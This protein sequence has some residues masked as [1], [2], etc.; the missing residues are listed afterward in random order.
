YPWKN[1]DARLD[2][3][4]EKVQAIAAASDA[5]KWSRSKTFEAIWRA[6]HL[7]A[8]AQVPEVTMKASPPVPFLSEP[9]YCCAEPTK[10]QLVSL[11]LAPVKKVASAVAATTAESFV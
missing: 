8:G 5:A 1:P 7:A 2:V 4:S 11:G 6:A 10:D 9:W 3:L